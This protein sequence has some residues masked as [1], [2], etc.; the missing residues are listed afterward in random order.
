MKRIKELIKYSSWKGGNTFRRNIKININ[1][2]CNVQTELNFW[3][4][5]WDGIAYTINDRISQNSQLLPEEIRQKT[6]QSN[7]FENR[8]MHILRKKT[9]LNSLS[10][11]LLPM[12][13]PFYPTNLIDMHLK[14]LRFTYVS[15][16]INLTVR[17]TVFFFLYC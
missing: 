15:L 4:N 9:R 8:V 5:C 14:L 17:I 13:Y 6:K 2:H 7:F 3:T 11:S 1:Y 16:K 12:S 10:G